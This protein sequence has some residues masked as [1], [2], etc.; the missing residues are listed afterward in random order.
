MEGGRFELLVGEDSVGGFVWMAGGIA[1]CFI[2]G[3]VEA[4]RT[5]TAVAMMVAFVFR[6]MIV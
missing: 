6:V 1:R 5:E 3:A 4:A 2:L